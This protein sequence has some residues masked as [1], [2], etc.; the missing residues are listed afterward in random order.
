VDRTF[1][2]DWSGEAESIRLRV[3]CVQSA[4]EQKI[5]PIFVKPRLRDLRF[6]TWLKK[7][8][9]KLANGYT[10]TLFVTFATFYS[11]LHRFVQ[12]QFGHNFS[13]ILTPPLLL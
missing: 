6:N 4:N 10:T 9:F 13:S 2:S 7:L 11:A 5:V 12:S 8:I 1:T 3:V